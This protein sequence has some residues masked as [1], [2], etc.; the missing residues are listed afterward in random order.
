MIYCMLFWEFLK[1][2][3]FSFG[4][5]YGAVPLIHESILRMQ[6]MDEDMFQNM[7]AVSE[8]TPGPIMVNCATYIG[9]SQGGIFGALLATTGVVLPAF[10]IILL[11]AAFLQSFIRSEKVQCVLKGIKPALIGVILSTGCVMAYKTLLPGLSTDTGS[12]LDLPTLII[13][14]LLAALM[15]LYPKLCKKE[16]PPIALIITAAILGILI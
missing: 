1:I 6:W 8:A 16:F 7:L 9:N 4:G 5:A 2:G 13:F 15:I 11:I 14:L 10:V 3:L 12:I